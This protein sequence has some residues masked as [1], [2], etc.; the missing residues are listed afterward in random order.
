[1]ATRLQKM[2]AKLNLKATTY[3]EL[4]YRLN[5]PISYLGLRDHHANRTSGE[6]VADNV[7]YQS[8]IGRK[9]DV[10][11]ARDLFFNGIMERT[12]AAARDLLKS[13]DAR[14]RKD[15]AW[16]YD[17]Q[18]ELADEGI[19]F[20]WE[21]FESPEVALKNYAPGEGKLFEGDALPQSLHAFGN[22]KGEREMLRQATPYEV[23]MLFEFVYRHDHRPP[24]TSSPYP[25]LTIGTPGSPIR[26]TEVYK[27]YMR[28]GGGNA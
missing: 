24:G 18:D 3:Q 13:A 12:N 7:S 17:V 14:A 26:G 5:I 16:A 23:G 22:Q 1:M 8:L 11:A 10:Q 4:W 25:G 2:N 9:V 6:N 28:E 15:V 20:S 27:R 19:P 21:L